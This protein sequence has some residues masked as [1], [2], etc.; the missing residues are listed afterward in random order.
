ME[1]FLWG[2][3]ATIIVVTLF[4]GVVR[5][6]WVR[7]RSLREVSGFTIWIDPLDSRGK[8]YS[9]IGATMYYVR[10]PDSK[11]N[12]ALPCLVPFAL[13]QYIKDR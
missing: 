6:W 5:K 9:D 10:F 2:M 7:R 3:L 12:V 4:Q 11:L 1:N 13:E 8:P